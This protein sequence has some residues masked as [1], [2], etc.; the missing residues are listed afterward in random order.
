MSQQP[1]NIAVLGFSTFE[2]GAFEAFFKMV[3]VSRPPGFL[4]TRDTSAADLIFLNATGGLD[5]H[6][7]M[8]T[9]ANGR[10]VIVIG[11]ADASLGVATLPRPIRLTSALAL[12]NQLIA[13]A[14]ADK[15]NRPQQ[16]NPAVTAMPA[17]AVKPADTAPSTISP[18]FWSLAPGQKFASTQAT[19]PQAV[20]AAQTM[21]DALRRAEAPVMRA[22]PPAVTAPLAPPVSISIG[23]V[24]K[25]QEIPASQKRAMAPNAEAAQVL[26]RFA[27][28]QRANVTSSPAVVSPPVARAAMNESAGLP[29]ELA[30]DDILV[31]DDSDIALKFMQ[32]HLG[33]FG[34]RVHLAKSGEECLMMLNQSKFRCVFL[35]V[36]MTGIDGYQT[37]RVIKQRKYPD[38]SAPTVVMMT[39]RSGAI[40]RVR[41]ALAGC[42]GYLVK[43]VDETKLIK[44]LFQHKV[45]SSPTTATNMRKRFDTLGR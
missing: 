18:A 16:P 41:G 22:V 15:L 8:R 1:H 14:Q 37:C 44:A 31:V 21:Q 3:G 24:P 35:D 28:T 2:V 33:S 4:V 6:R 43:P 17:R 42:D 30:Y 9:E 23:A 19:V 34:F 20:N 13:K 27:V 29:P 10:P 36:M 5:V 40:D 25:E 26:N 45:S 7:F 12:A 38:G 32:E 11:D 39:S